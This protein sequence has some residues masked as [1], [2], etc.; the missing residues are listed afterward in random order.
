MSRLVT[1]LDPE[2]RDKA[3]ELQRLCALRGKNIKFTQ[4]YR[5]PEEQAALY[6]K[7]RTAPGP[8]VTHA[9]PGYSWH[10]FR[11][12]F[13]VAEAD[14]TPY[15]MGAP[16]ISAEDEGWWEEVGMIGES[17]GLEWGGRWKHPDRPHFQLTGNRS[18]A[19]ARAESGHPNPLPAERTA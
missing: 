8:I 3:L 4:T 12:A 10:E 9:P 17:L 7:G 19:Q 6:A 16:G 5:T 14:A 1:D 2:V 15:D 18:L 13:D 11:C